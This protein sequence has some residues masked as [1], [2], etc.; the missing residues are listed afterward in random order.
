MTDKN[1]LSSLIIDGSAGSMAQ[2]L[3]GG[4]GA[5]SEESIRRSIDIA[6]NLMQRGGT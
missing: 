1:P 3:R 5:A 2:A 4:G 6:Q